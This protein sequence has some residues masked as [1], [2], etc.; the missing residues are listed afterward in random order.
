MGA[1][2]WRWLRVRIL[3]LFDAAGQH[4]PL[5]DGSVHTVAGSRLARHFQN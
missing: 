3:G 5:A 2:S 1:R 4:V